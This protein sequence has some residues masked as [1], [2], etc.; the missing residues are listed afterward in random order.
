MN[1][2]T[3]LLPWPPSV[4][5]MW[6]SPRS[7]RLA[8]R[9]LLSAAGRS[10]RQAVADAMILQRVPWHSFKGKLGVHITAH[11]PDRRRRDLDNLPKAA[12]DGLQHAGVIV[13][14]SEIDELRIVRSRIVENGRL[15]VLVWELP[16]DTQREVA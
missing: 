5:V 7:G 12:L 9:T 10:Y 11:P 14:D 16:C 1:E 8:G 13:D 2:L 15:I 6:R 3:F 4:N